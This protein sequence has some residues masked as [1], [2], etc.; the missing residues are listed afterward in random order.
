SGSKGFPDLLQFQRDR[1]V[2]WA[3]KA[4]HDQLAPRQRA[5]LPALVK[6]GFPTMV[7]RLTESERSRAEFRRMRSIQ[8]NRNREHWGAFWR[9]SAGKKIWDVIVQ[10]AR[11]YFPFP[12]GGGGHLPHAN[13]REGAAD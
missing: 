1:V 12:A 13:R 7:V 6:L 5:V 4:P 10:P 3:V 11:R 2:G 9:T 8:L